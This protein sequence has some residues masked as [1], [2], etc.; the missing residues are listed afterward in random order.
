MDKL[1]AMDPDESDHESLNLDMRRL[2]EYVVIV[3]STRSKTLHIPNPSS[4]KEE[5]WP[6]CYRKGW[7]D[8]EEFLAKDIDVFPPGYRRFCLNCRER[9]SQ[10]IQNL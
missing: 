6:L 4:T 2:T 5:P 3:P 10:R 1:S 7:G 9:L 8:E